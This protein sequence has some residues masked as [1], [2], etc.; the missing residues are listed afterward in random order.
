VKCLYTYTLVR[1]WPFRDLMRP[2]LPLKLRVVLSVEQ[3]WRVLDQI[4]LPH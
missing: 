4:Q 2:A 1:R 3:V